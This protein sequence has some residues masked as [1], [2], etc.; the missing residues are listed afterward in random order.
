MPYILKTPPAWDSERESERRT[1]REN[2][3]DV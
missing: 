2:E 3:G 1:Q